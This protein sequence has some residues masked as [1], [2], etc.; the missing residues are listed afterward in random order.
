[1][2]RRCGGVLDLAADEARY[3]KDCCNKFRKNLENVFSVT[4]PDYALK[5]IC[6][7]IHKNRFSNTWSTSEL[8]DKEYDGELQRQVIS[9]IK[10]QLG[11]DYHVV[12]LD[13]PYSSVLGHIKHI[14][15]VLK[16][17]KAQRE[18]EDYEDALVKKIKA[19]VNAINTG[20]LNKD[21]DLSDFTKERIIEQTS[22]TL[23]RVVS[24]LVSNGEISKPALSLSQS[25]Q[26]NIDGKPNQTTLG[27][28]IKL[29]HR[30]GSRD[31]IDD[32]HS[33]GW[34]ADYYE[35]LRFRKSCAKFTRDNP[36]LLHRLAGLS[37]EV[38]V[39]FGWYDNVDMFLST[40]NGRRETHIMSN[41]VPSS[42]CR[43]N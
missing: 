35:I 11:E 6:E 7:D 25:I 23:L 43:H 24:H 27:T 1:M 13:G 8:F 34:V 21:Y 37:K 14:G 10:S 26:Y 2:Q 28:G 31:L 42:S 39:I 3:H 20:R 4:R 22:P 18:T 17:V 38:G 32:L 30:H 41:Q 12:P 9:N 5:K 36:N 19:E 16:I 40:P 15:K 33:H 29:H